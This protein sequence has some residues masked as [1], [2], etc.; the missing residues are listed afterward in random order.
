MFPTR[1]FL[2]PG[3][4]SE[5]F[6]SSAQARSGQVEGREAQVV[7]CCVLVPPFHSHNFLWLFEIVAN[8]VQV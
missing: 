5:D 8:L 6:E 4:H 7:L 2:T 3:A 1:C